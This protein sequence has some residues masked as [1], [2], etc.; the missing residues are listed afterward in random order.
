[1]NKIKVS[2]I[3]NTKN[4]S[5]TL[6]QAIR[7]VSWSDDI[8]VVDMGS[9][10]E[11]KKIAKKYT[12]SVHDFKDVGFVEP[13]RNFA[14]KKA[15]HDWIFILDADEEASEKFSELI[16]NL[17]NKDVDVYDIPRKNIVFDK[18][19]QHTGWW[20]DYQ[21]RLFKK[22]H[23]TWSDKIHSTPE[24]RG[25][26]VKLP[27]KEEIAII[28]H[29]Y[30]SIEQFIDR[31]NKYTTIEALQQ[32]GSHTSP[33]KLLSEGFSEFYSRFFKNQGHKDN[34]HGISLSLLQ[35]FYQV[36]TQL[37]IWQNRG[38]ENIDEKMSKSFSKIIKDLK[39]WN[40]YYHMHTSKN[41][42]IKL[43]WRIRLKLKI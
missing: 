17:I 35:M 37:K 4:S 38:F 32:K 19:I 13:A 15:K 21:R 23:V 30:Q 16:P 2:V 10:D 39:Y 42:L 41:P 18:W 33:S 22:D 29:N 7:S 31:L 25:K 26:I 6:E 1:M 9:T 3:I 28:H 12:E 36:T 24:V 27:N 20:P 43:Y 8:V 40:A 11:T 14:I 5:N 34:M